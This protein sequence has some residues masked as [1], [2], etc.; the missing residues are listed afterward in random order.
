MKKSEMVAKIELFLRLNHAS[1]RHLNK[2]E[3]I[4]RMIERAGM[5]PPSTDYFVNNYPDEMHWEEVHDFHR[6]E[7]EYDKKTNTS[8]GTSG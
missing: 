2:A 3:D 7:P 6:W 1:D 5:L 4:V 8:S